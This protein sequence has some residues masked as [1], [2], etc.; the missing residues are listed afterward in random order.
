MFKLLLFLCM[1]SFY[2][3][4]VQAM[5]PKVGNV[6]T[7]TRAEQ[8]ARRSTKVQAARNAIIRQLQNPTCDFADFM[9]NLTM[10]CKT[11]QIRIKDVCALHIPGEPSLIDIAINSGHPVSVIQILADHNSPVHYVESKTPTLDVIWN[12]VN[13]QNRLAIITWLIESDPYKPTGIV[14]KPGRLGIKLDSPM[15]RLIGTLHRKY[16]FFEQ[17]IQVMDAVKI[18]AVRNTPGF[19]RELGEKAEWVTE[20]LVGEN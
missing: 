6:R 20:F 13:N 10:Y 18:I 15:M 4:N 9:K 7:L 12:A 1:F 19:T 8:D 14:L 16:P 11:Q 17:L 3:T 5:L 2:N